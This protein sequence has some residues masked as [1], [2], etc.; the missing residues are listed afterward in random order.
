MKFKG[1][2]QWFDEKALKNKHI[3]VYDVK[4]AVIRNNN[5]EIIFEYEYSGGKYQVKLTSPE[6]IRF[7]GDYWRLKGSNPQK[8]GVCDFVLY[9]NKDEYFLKGGYSSAEEGSGTW[10]VQL[11]KEV[12]HD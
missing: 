4:E 6:G 9:E 10:W 5:S 1:K 8:V 7:T 12:R 11:N 2:Q 3:E